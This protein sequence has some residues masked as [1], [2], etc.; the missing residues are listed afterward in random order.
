MRDKYNMN[1]ETARQDYK[2]RYEQMVREVEYKRN[3]TQDIE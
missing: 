2:E 3:L 1:I